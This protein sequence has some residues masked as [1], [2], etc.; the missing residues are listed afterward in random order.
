MLVFSFHRQLANFTCHRISLFAVI[1]PIYL[2]YY[3]DLK[4]SDYKITILIPLFLI[5]GHI[6]PQSF[7][8]QF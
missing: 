4:I 2:T 1:N 7:K 8:K 5:Y 3:C 6:S